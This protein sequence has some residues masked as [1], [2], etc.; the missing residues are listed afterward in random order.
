MEKFVLALLATIVFAKLI[1]I[2][3][4]A[5]LIGGGT[6]IILTAVKEGKQL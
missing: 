2:I 6:A 4:L 1:P 3:L 5:L